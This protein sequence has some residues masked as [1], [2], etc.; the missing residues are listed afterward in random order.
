MKLVNNFAFCCLFVFGCFCMNFC[1]W[2]NLLIINKSQSQIAAQISFPYFPWMHI[3]HLVSLCLLS[4][5]S[6]RRAEPFPSLQLLQMDCACRTTAGAVSMHL[7][8]H[9]KG[10]RRSHKHLASVFSTLFF[11][12][13]PHSHHIPPSITSYHYWP[14]LQLQI[15][16]YGG[17][18]VTCL[19]AL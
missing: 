14:S 4:H 2:L 18:N 10:N 12:S 3:V 6:H 9:V 11:K 16:H 1:D 5:Y 13:T 17:N 7:L 8:L 19:K 15:A